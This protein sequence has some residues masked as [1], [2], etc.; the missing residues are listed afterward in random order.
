MASMEN[1]ILNAVQIPAFMPARDPI[2]LSLLPWMY[3]KS[4]VRD[5]DEID[6]SEIKMFSGPYI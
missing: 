6:H 5:N 2:R 4:L 1:S 3:F